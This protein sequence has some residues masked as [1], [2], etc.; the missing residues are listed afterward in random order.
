MVRKPSLLLVLTL[1]LAAAVP[2]A[3]APPKVSEFGKY[4]GYS[5]AV[6]DGW[7]RSSQYVPMRDGTRLAV[8]IV[9]PTLHG[10]VATER[11]P[12]VWTHS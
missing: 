8:D 2:A 3:A 12:V 10:Q 4:S 6:Y 5:E 7:V 11:L 9:R 1:A